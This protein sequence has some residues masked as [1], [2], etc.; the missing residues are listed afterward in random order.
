MHDVQEIPIDL[1][2]DNPFNSRMNYSEAD[3]VVARLSRGIRDARWNKLVTA[4]LH[5][6][7]MASMRASCAR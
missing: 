3:F 6:A 5:S 4:K 2:D 7:A 1:I